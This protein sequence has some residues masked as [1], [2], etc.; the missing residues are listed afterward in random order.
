MTV[1]KFLSEKAKEKFPKTGFFIIMIGVL[2]TAGITALR[3]LL[4]II[5][6]L[7]YILGAFFKPAIIQCY[8]SIEHS[9]DWLPFF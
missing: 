2:A 7:K 9:F 5:Y 6:T 3:K 1:Q 8:F 4:N